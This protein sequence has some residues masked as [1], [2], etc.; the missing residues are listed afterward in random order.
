MPRH[1][2]DHTKP[3][4]CT[5]QRRAMRTQAPSTPHNDSPPGN[6]QHTPERRARQVR[7]A[8]RSSDL[9]DSRPTRTRLKSHLS[10][11]EDEGAHHRTRRSRGSPKT[12]G[13][14]RR[15]PAQR[16]HGGLRRTRHNSRRLPVDHMMHDSCTAN[17]LRCF[18]TDIT[19]SRW[20]PEHASGARLMMARA[21]LRLLCRSSRRNASTVH[22][23]KGAPRITRTTPHAHHHMA[24]AE[25]RRLDAQTVAPHVDPRTYA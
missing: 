22:I 21:R 6:I 15:R 18:I 10:R 13:R 9:V 2:S 17:A 25:A 1:M 3:T 16:L 7:S 19:F 24:F 23:D 14:R 11:R 4:W 20:H 8:A 12:P 5:T